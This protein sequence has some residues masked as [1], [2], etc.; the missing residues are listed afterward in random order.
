MK[1]AVRWTIVFV[2]LRH[3]V[4]TVLLSSAMDRIVFPLPFNHDEIIHT[5]TCSC[6]YSFHQNS[7]QS[8]KWQRVLKLF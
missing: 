5:I 4:D 1:N 8:I 3:G 2:A 6:S 7:R